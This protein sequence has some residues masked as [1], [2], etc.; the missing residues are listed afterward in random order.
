[1]KPF[2]VAAFCALLLGGVAIGFG[3]ILMRLS[4][5]N[6]VASAFWRLALAAPVLWVWALGSAARDQAGGKRT[7]L[8]KVL[9]SS[10]AFFGIELGIWHL[11]LHYTNIA[12]S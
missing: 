3:G 5:V 8:S 9:L 1:M 2:P 10:G 7:D 12:N 6:A 11:S 4:D